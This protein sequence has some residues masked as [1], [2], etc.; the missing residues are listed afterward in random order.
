M[1]IIKNIVEK[2]KVKAVRAF[3]LSQPAIAY[4]YEE[5]KRLHLNSVSNMV[6]IMILEYKER[7]EKKA[8][9]AQ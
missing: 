8:A 2:K 7:N 9:S 3:S 4:L 1:D 6:E 5:A